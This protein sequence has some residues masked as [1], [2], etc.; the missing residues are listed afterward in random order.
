M[1]LS[2]FP[3]PTAAHRRPQ[4]PTDAPVCHWPPDMAMVLDTVSQVMDMKF[5]TA[6]CAVSTKSG[7]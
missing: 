3:N 5:W 1:S 4:L 6:L 2:G 7:P